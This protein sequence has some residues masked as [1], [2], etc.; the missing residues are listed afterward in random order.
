MTAARS[1]PSRL[2]PRR[3]AVLGLA[4]AVAASAILLLSLDSHLTFIA[5]DWMLLVKRQ[6]WGA[7]YFLYPFRGNIVLAPGLVYKVLRA[8][9][10]MG[11]AL[12]YY[13]AAIGT[14]LASAR[15]FCSPTCAAGSVTGSL[16]W[17]RS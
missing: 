16:F 2:D 4:I 1:S 9:F 5:D 6:G 11:S 10:G 17:R 7:P 12:P 14:F 8:I 3:A 15:R 13:V